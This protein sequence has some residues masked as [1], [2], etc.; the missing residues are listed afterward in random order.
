MKDL[1][2]DERSRSKQDVGRPLIPRIPGSENVNTEKALRKIEKCKE[3]DADNW[4]ETAGI[5]RT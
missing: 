5:S 2:A 3:T 4:K 1:L